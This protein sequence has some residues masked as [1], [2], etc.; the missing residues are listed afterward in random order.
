MAKDVWT[1][2]RSV[3]AGEAEVTWPHDLAG[4]FDETELV[5]QFRLSESMGQAPEGWLRQTLGTWHLVHDTTLPVRGITSCGLP[6]GWIL[7]HPVTAEGA[8]LA[9]D[10]EV[11]MQS[12]AVNTDSVED[13]LDELAGS[14][15]AIIIGLD[16]PRVYLDALGSMGVVYSADQ[17]IVASS[18]FLIPYSRGSDDRVGFVRG[19]AARPPHL[20]FGL[21]VR[22]SVDW[23]LPGHYL[24]LSTWQAVRHWPR[25]GVD[26]TTEIEE[27]V[28]FVGHRL[29]RNISAV[30]EIG[31][32]QMSLTAGKDTRMLL[33]CARDFISDIDFVTDVHVD[34]GG[35]FDVAVARHLARK[36]GLHHRV[37]YRPQRKNSE[38]ARLLYRT[39]GFSAYDW[40][41]QKAGG[42]TSRDNQT[43]PH[44]SGNYGEMVRIPA[45]FK[46]LDGSEP[47]TILRMFELRE[48]PLFPEVVERGARWLDELPVENPHTVMDLRA[49]EAAGWSAFLAYGYADIAKFICKPFND[50]RV[51]EALISLPVT[52]RRDSGV[53]KDLISSRWPELLAV[54]FNDATFGPYG[55]YRRA[56]RLAKRVLRR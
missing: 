7:G 14:F 13:L 35:Y 28:E 24:N 26:F 21:T 54:P 55:W 50:R 44:I 48:Q 29:R 46:H 33:A 17:R 22:T 12:R 39:S 45:Y 23:L 51:L 27:T 56:R 37:V 20:Y 19:R 9:T 1:F 11:G 30:V 18:V 32:T 52:Y 38:L 53:V 40:R 16:D 6:I 42:A 8:F 49:L 15:V 43:I 41:S 3:D 4:R 31:R 34:R 5:G 36:A 10:F 2:V 25:R 47:L